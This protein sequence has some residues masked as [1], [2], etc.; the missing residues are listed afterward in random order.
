MIILYSIGFEQYIYSQQISVSFICEF[1]FKYSVSDMC[2]CVESDPTLLDDL[3]T[4]VCW[5]R[6]LK[7]IVS[8]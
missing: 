7:S 5:G 1:I 4:Y 2:E 6:A 8:Y 3:H